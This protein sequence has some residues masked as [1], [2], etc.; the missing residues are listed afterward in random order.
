MV[1]STWS[2]I[3]IGLTS[4]QNDNEQ[5]AKYSH[6]YTSTNSAHRSVRLRKGK[7]NASQDNNIRKLLISQMERKRIIP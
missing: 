1:S 4:R 2:T 3:S 6:F 7:N 5:I